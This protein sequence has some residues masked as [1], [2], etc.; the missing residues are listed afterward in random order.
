MRVPVFLAACLTAGLPL[1]AIDFSGLSADP[2]RI[3][4]DM[5]TGL[6]AVYVLPSTVAVTM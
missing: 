1:S 4:T 3:A 5:S 2:V 6:E